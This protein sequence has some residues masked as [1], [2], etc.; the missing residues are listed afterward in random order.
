V[1]YTVVKK[2]KGSPD[3]QSIFVSL[4]ELIATDPKVANPL[5][6]WQ[7]VTESSMNPSGV[8]AR[9]GQQVK[10]DGQAWQGLRE[11]RNLPWEGGEYAK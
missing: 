10:V 5:A 4:N 11:I 1:D 9:D 7:S 3:W 2:R 8:I 6:N